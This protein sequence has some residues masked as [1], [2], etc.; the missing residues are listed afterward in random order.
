[1]GRAFGTAVMV[2]TPDRKRLHVK[3]R[4]RSED[5]TEMDAK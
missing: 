4:H 3:R 1:M 2:G 5:S